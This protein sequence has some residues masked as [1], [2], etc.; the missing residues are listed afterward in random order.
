MLAPLAP[1]PSD[2]RPL[3]LMI[4]LV[5]IM[6]LLARVEFKASR[7]LYLA[8]RLLMLAAYEL[9]LGCVRVLLVLSRAIFCD[10]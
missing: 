5:F 2:L 8:S 6:T 7:A 9:L 10:P 1:N 3:D 4:W